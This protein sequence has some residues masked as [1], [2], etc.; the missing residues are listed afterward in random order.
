MLAALLCSTSKIIEKYEIALN[1][2]CLGHVTKM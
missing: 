1:V 2:K